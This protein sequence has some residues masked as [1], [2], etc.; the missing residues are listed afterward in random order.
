[1]LKGGILQQAGAPLELYDDPD[2]R[3]VAGFIGSPAMNFLPARISGQK[4][5]KATLTLLEGEHALEAPIS[6][7]VT[8]G[9]EV[10]IGIRPEHFRL[11]DNGIAANVE[12][13]EELGD[14]SYLYARTVGGREVIVQRQGSRQ[15]LDGTM[16]H[17]TADARN[18][19]VFDSKGQRLR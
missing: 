14:I 6:A 15:R 9:E 19:L 17:L 16:V 18:I 8:V 10:E 12:V 13:A 5:G 1:V 4:D 11:S 7:P 3:F 2:N